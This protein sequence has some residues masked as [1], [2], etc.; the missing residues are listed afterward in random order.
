M[1]MS[2][3]LQGLLANFNTPHTQMSFSIALYQASITVIIL[4]IAKARC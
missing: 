1:A 2:T 4:V 3:P